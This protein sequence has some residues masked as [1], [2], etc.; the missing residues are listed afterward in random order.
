MPEEQPW[1]TDDEKLEEGEVT[2]EPGEKEETET[3]ASPAEKIED[4]E[5]LPFHKHPRFKAITTENREL[6]ARLDE[7]SQ[8]VQES[9]ANVAQPTEGVKVPDWFALAYGD[10]PEAYQALQQFEQAREQ[11]LKQSIL[12]EIA[13]EKTQKKQQDNAIKEFIDTEINTLKDEGNS[14]DANELKK[15]VL[16]NKLFD[17]DGKLNFRAGLMLLKASKPDKTSVK[18]EVANLTAPT[19]GGTTARADVTTAKD[20][21]R[22][23]SALD[24]LKNL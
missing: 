12:K 4:E 23:S 15:I 1:F 16:D 3:P 24:F 10:N 13:E 14:F 8:T 18:K 7:L 22:A 9:L 21:R 2:P 20:L 17:A 11:E 6:K 5:E 19:S